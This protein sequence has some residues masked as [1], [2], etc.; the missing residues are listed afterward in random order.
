MKYLVM[1]SEKKGSH[2][3]KQ[4][5]PKKGLKQQNHENK[6]ESSTGNEKNRKS[7]FLSES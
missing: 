2:F 7:I 1:A 5:F 3:S 4:S 6:F